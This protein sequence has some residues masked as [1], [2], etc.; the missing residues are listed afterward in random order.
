MIKVFLFA[1]PGDFPRFAESICKLASLMVFFFRQGHIPEGWL[2]IDKIYSLEMC[3]SIERNYLQES[4]GM[5][6][7]S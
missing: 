4:E 6:K 3:F 1:I 5:E 7:Q 2:K